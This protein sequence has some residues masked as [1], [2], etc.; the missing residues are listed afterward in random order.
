M[1]QF[2]RFFFL[3]SVIY[4]F[5]DLGVPLLEENEIEDVQADCSSLAIDN[6]IAD[7]VSFKLSPPTVDLG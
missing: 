6:S 7:N 1:L 5:I 3:I 4:C 2:Y